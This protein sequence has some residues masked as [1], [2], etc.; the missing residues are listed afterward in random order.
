MM[1]IP[2]FWIREKCRG[3]DGTMWKLRG[4]S[5][6][7]MEEARSRLETR[8]QL[9]K[10]FATEQAPNVEVYRSELRALD[11]LQ[12]DEYNTLMLEPVLH[13]LGEGELITRNRY[14]VSVL[15][16]SSLCFVDV[17][18]FP[19]SFTQKLLSF[20]GKK[21]DAEM[22]LME[23]LRSLCNEDE[24]LGARLYRTRRGW[25]VMLRSQGI[26]PDSDRMKQLFKALHADPLYASLCERQ[27][28]WRARLS[29]KP[30]R[31]GMRGFPCPDSSDSYD[32]DEV[33]AWVSAYEQACEGKAVCRL[34]ECF[35]REIT[36]E[37]VEWHDLATRA[38]IPDLPLA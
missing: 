14:G 29:P 8:R 1:K 10:S 17:D 21:T 27:G 22:L 5:Y 24:S 12:Q 31:V 26:S 7:S 20:F 6:N 35:G 4:I 38:R 23:R 28:C 2:P 3:C 32:S 19:L 25:R 11:E 37:L 30:Y 33:M 16:S 34:V 36:G 9:R 13:V 15:N 18:K